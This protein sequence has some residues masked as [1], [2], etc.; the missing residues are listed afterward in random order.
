MSESE[1]DGFV[2][3][4]RHWAGYWSLL[5]Q[6]T[7]NAFNDKMAQ[8]ILIPLGGAVG[9]SVESMAGL[10]ISLP[11]V[12]FAPLAGWLSDRYSKRAVVFYSAVLQWVV[13]LWI[14]AAVWL[15]HLPMALSGFF[16]LAVQSAFFSPAKMGLN[17]ELLGSRHLGF[18]T[19]VQQ[20][21]AMLA[22]LTGQIVAGKLFDDRF[23]HHGGSADAAWHAAWGPLA[24]LAVCAAPA[25]AMAWVLPAV[26]AQSAVPFRTRLLV[27]HFQSLEDLWADKPLRWASWGVAFFWGFAA[28]LNLWSVK[29]AKVLTAGG[30]GFGSLSSL[31]MAAASLGMAGGFGC[32]SWLLRRGVNLGWV[33]LSAW[34]MAVF[35]LGMAVMPMGGR[36][37]FLLFVTLHPPTLLAAA[38]AEPGCAG[39]LLM[40]ALLAFVSALFL[41]PLNAW[42]QDR[43]PADKRGELQSAVNLQDCV[44]GIAGVVLITGLEFAAAA[45]GIDALAALRPHMILIA[46]LCLLAGVLIVRLLPADFL[47]LISASLL[48]VVYRIETL[49]PERVPAKGGILLLPNHVTFAD[50]FFLSAA[51]R[52]P[53]RF[54]MDG[55][56]A[57]NRAIGMFTRIFAT[58]NIRR[59]QPIEAIRT[60]IGG[61]KQGEA[62]C[63]FPEGQLTR[64]GAL[65]PLQR[66]FELIARK[67]A[68]P[69][70]P[71][72]MDGSWG[73]IHSYE[74]GRFFRKLPRSE[75][76]RLI[77]A[78]GEPIDPNKAT[79]E[80]VRRAL[81]QASADAVAWR[82]AGNEWKKR[83]PKS[84]PQLRAP[85][86]ARQAEERRALWANGHQIGMVAALARRKPWFVLAG[87]RA[88]DELLGLCAAFP[89]LFD[90]PVTVRDGF[91]ASV[92][93]V[94]VGGE[95][96]RTQLECYQ[97]TAQLVFHD[98]SPEAARRPVERA[99]VL[100]CPGLAI[101]GRVVSMSMPCPEQ[102]SDGFPP[103]LG[104]RIHTWG[105]LL[106]GWA[107]EGEGAVIRRVLGPAA[108]A[109]L[110]LPPGMTMDEEG[111][112][113][114]PAAMPK[115]MV[116][117]RR[118]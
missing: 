36:E 62:L 64:T 107:V 101:H 58:V 92:D 13:L 93:G 27:G 60:V 32:A 57:R 85:F 82:F 79:L 14:A 40:M 84:V 4:K 5:V 22:M 71:V 51:M 2:P 116:F 90:T 45:A 109:G 69:L 65:C 103:Q 28:Y 30:E 94:W 110:D 6:Q 83:V 100:H 52:R 99:G 97:I 46:A 95:D 41:A 59:D 54:V 89:A 26:R 113:V 12:L 86:S 8:F 39:F 29:L 1:S 38:V 91:D 15:R 9:F 11:F 16:A 47:R 20:M 66:G 35:S 68:H 17:K 74:G 70:V 102:A 87:D 78:L 76:K 117:E 34:L 112:L 19:S 105:R 73:S 108:P 24:V 42:M 96:L 18:A 72:W 63:L 48:S 53:L 23:S 114:D 61:L 106:P 77:C 33:P 7:Q 43:Y 49:H 81:L 21:L 44:A 31:F 50:S 88:L 3:G 55:V 98:F 37:A 25:L 56:F 115:P 80:V 75:C 118:A 10:M 67:A 104:R 111:F